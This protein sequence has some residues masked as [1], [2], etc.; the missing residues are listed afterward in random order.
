MAARADGAAGLVEGRHPEHGLQ[1][2]PRRPARGPEARDR[3]L[4]GARRMQ[5]EGA[6]LTVYTTEHAHSSIAKAVA[7]AGFGLDNLRS[8]GVDPVTYAMRPEALASVLEADVAVGRRPAAVVVNIGTTGTTAVDPLAEIVPLAR[9]YGM[10]VHVDAA[11]AGSALLLPEMRWLIEGVEGADSLSWNPH[12]WLGTV[13]DCS[14][15]YVADPG[16]LIRVMSTNP[17]Y[18]R[19]A[20]DGP[21]RLDR[22]LHRQSGVERLQCDQGRSAIVRAHL[23]PRFEGTENPGQRH[24][25]R[26]DQYSGVG[27]LGTNSGYRRSV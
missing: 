10:W 17:S 20:V 15:L 3:L 25:P 12:K 1:R 27:R 18:L 22:C 9:R 5:A 24:Q 11:M 8:V 23:D 21:E 16:H 4:R 14:L 2:V 13:L 6:P 7:L 26:S 19:S